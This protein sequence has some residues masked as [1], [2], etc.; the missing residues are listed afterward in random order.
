MVVRASLSKADP[1]AVREVFSLLARSKTA[2][3]AAAGEFDPIPFGV[4][5]LRSS[6]DIAIAYCLRQGLIARRLSVDEL[7]DDVTRALEP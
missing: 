7:F 3:A 6:L 5:A 4:A 1:Q 2:G